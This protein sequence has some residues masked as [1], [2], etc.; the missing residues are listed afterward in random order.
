MFLSKFKPKRKWSYYV[1]ETIRKIIMI[2]ALCVFTY[3]S[4][5]LTNIYLDYNEAD[6]NYQNMEQQFLIPNI[7]P[8][9]ETE[10]EEIETDIK[11]NVIHSSQ[12]IKEFTFDFDALRAVNNSAVGWIMQEDIFSYPIVQGLDNTY[13]LTHDVAHNGTKNGAIF[14]DYRIEEGLEARNCIIYGHNM[15]NG[16]MF[17]SLIKYRDE[18]YYKNHKTMDIYVGKDLYKYHVI[19]A[20]ETDH[21]GYTYTYDF[22]DDAAF[23]EYID[24][25]VARKWYR[26]D[27]SDKVTTEDK[28]ITLSTCTNMDDTKRFIVHLVRGEK[29]E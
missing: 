11:G 13:Y 6:S 22:E 20:Y 18:S 8:G 5:E 25:A 3:S 28:V 21:I 23:Q 24:A 14:V 7:S 4:Y 26:T 29:I 1:K 10:S 16:A 17:G 2:S 19:S 15:R 9:S 27:Y 12:G